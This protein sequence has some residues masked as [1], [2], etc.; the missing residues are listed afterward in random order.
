MQEIKAKFF[1]L[2]SSIKSFARRLERVGLD[3]PWHR[4][5][6]VTTILAGDVLTNE[7]IEDLSKSFNK[8]PKAVKFILTR[9]SSQTRYVVIFG[10]SEYLHV[11][12]QE[13]LGVVLELI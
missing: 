13:H 3:L 1:W 2:R 11:F 10:D 4:G 5:L 6:L 7:Q 9:K 8:N 12:Y